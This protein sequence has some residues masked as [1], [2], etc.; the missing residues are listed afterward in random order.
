[1]LAQRK[2][3]FA[4][5][6]DAPAHAARLF[7]DYLQPTPTMVVALYYPV[8]DELDTMVLAK[9]L[10]DKRVKLALP[11]VEKKNNPL[12]FREWQEHTPLE[13]G[14]YNIPVP[15]NES[16]VVVPSH[17]VVPLVAYNSNGARLGYGGGYYDRTLALLRENHQICAIGY[18]FGAQHVDDLPTDKLDQP[19]DWIIT[20]R[21]AIKV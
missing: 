5:R 4:A 6:P 1:M 19:L 7:M 14:H 18:G 15:T 10:S 21:E 9:A 2:I 13:N 11:V 20:E 16:P 17:I 8:N 12:V 3:A